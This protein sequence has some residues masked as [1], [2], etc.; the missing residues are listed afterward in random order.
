MSIILTLLAV[1]LS[2]PQT[3]DTAHIVGSPKDAVADPVTGELIYTDPISGD[4]LTTNIE[5]VVFIENTLDNTQKL[6]M[7][8]EGRTTN[9]RVGIVTNLAYTVDPVDAGTFEI[10]A[11][12]S[13]A[14]QAYF[15]P[16]DD[17]VGVATITSTGLNKLGNPINGSFAVQV[18][19]GP[20][21]TI[22]IQGLTPVAK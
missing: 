19:A 10:P 11:D 6:P 1:I 17:F 16:A 20:A 13:G 2:I 8:I 22:N 15:V 21:L 7:H 5:N 18:L 4:T 9:D 3:G 12:T 14:I